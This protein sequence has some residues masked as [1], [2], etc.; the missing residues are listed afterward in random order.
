[1]KS[2]TSKIVRCLKEIDHEQIEGGIYALPERYSN[3]RLPASHHLIFGG[4]YPQFDLFSR[5]GVRALK[6]LN[7]R[8]RFEHGGAEASLQFIDIALTKVRSYGDGFQLDKHHGKKWV[9]CSMDLKKAVSKLVKEVKTVY[10]ANAFLVAFVFTDSKKRSNDLIAP[11]IA[12]GFLTRYD[13]TSS[14]ETW[15]DPHGRGIWTS[16]LCW[17]IR[18]SET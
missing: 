8:V 10:P 3:G 5:I 1:M 11:S 6:S 18:N 16:V 15:C 2:I 4:K 12:E 14:N 17:G 9:D 7:K 13:L